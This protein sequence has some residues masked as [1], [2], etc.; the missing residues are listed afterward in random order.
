MPLNINKSVN[1]GKEMTKK[2][3]NLGMTPTGVGGD[4]P[5]SAFIKTQENIDEL[6]A[7][8]IDVSVLPASPVDLS[9][10]LISGVY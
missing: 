10:L 2:T 7:A 1:A 3:I 8:V 4:T 5:R 9:V 6:Y